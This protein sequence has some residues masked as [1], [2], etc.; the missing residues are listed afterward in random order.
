MNNEDQIERSSLLM[1]VDDP[2]APTLQAASIDPHDSD[3]TDGD[4]GDGTDGTDEG[5]DS[6][7]G[8]DGDKSDS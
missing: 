6:D 5:D 2:S 4:E 8:D 7:D 3:G 1:A